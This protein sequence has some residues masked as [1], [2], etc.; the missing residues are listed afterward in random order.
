MAGGWSAGFGFGFGIG[1]TAPSSF[2]TLPLPGWSKLKTPNWSTIVAPHV[3]GR[4]V[5]VPNYVFPLYDFQLTFNALDS[6]AGGTYQ[7]GLQSQQALMGFYNQVSGRFGQFLYPDPTDGAVTNQLIAYGDGATLAFTLGR[8]LTS[9]APIEPVGWVTSLSAVSLA[10]TPQASTNWALVAPNTVIFTTAPLG[11]PT[12]FQLLAETSATG[13]HSTNQAIASQTNGAIIVFN[14]PAFVGVRSALGITCSNGSTTIG[15]CN[16][17]LATAAVGTLAS[18]FT[19]QSIT[20]IGGGW[21]Q[22][23]VVF[24][25]AATGAPTFTVE[26]ENPF[27]TASYAGTAGDGVYIAGANWGVSGGAMVYLPAFS[28]VTNATLTAEAV[29]FPAAISGVPIT[30]TFAYSFLCR[31]TEDALEFEQFMNNL[32]MLKS[33]KFQSVRNGSFT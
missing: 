25:M 8:S 29:G 9:A 27:G 18:G 6:S 26:V 11:P 24:A 13:V 5:R 30:A 22:C 2:P 17:N 19:S 14:V 32:W 15:P 33:C 23:Q 31:F 21:Y 3:S 12:V 7:V 1:A 20:A 28:S 10:G 4:E 16:F